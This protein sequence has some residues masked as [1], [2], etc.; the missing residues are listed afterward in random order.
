MPVIDSYVFL[1]PNETPA[2]VNLDVTWVA[3]EMSRRLG[4]GASVPPS[5]PRAFVGTFSRARATGTFS[6]SEIGFEFQSRLASS[7][8]GYAQMGRQR[9][10]SFLR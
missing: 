4:A 1:G 3:T 10:G 9:N 7:D 5:D 2:T 6:G 8:R